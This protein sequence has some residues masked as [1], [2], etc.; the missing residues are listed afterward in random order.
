MIRLLVSIVI[1]HQIY[2]VPVPEISVH[3]P[4]ICNDRFI[5]VHGVK[6]LPHDGE[7]EILR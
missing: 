2:L 5:R 6:G 7:F 1:Q 3:L 4:C